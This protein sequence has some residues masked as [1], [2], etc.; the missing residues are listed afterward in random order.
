MILECTLEVA[1]EERG[2]SMHGAEHAMHQD[3]ILL[4]KGILDLRA[5]VPQA[6]LSTHA[7]T[8][9]QAVQ[10]QAQVEAKVPA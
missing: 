6:I 4:S 1:R 9:C 2:A 8:M 3:A 10:V 7:C 5:I